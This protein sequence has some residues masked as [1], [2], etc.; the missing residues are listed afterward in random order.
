ML[1]RRLLLVNEA[2]LKSAE[3]HYSDMRHSIFNKAGGNGLAGWAI[4]LPDLAVD[5]NYSY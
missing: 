3:R 1:A 4:A 5:A 2:G